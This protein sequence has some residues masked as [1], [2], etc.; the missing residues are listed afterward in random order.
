MKK[1]VQQ[2]NYDGLF[3]GDNADRA[4]EF[5]RF[6]DAASFDEKVGL[7]ANISFELKKPRA[8]K[9]VE[10]FNGAKTS[11]APSTRSRPL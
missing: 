11:N 2:G 6:I 4:F 8:L 5:K 1:L 7:P 3:N 9:N 10:L